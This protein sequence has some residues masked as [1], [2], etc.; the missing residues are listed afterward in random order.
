MSLT[1]VTSGSDVAATGLEPVSSD[2]EPEV[3]PIAPHRSY[4]VV[5]TLR[6][7]SQGPVLSVWFFYLKL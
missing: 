1:G 3:L 7:C 5:K 6:N 4:H 2:H